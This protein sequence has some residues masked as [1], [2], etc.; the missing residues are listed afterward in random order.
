[1]P[2]KPPVTFPTEKRALAEFGKRLKLARLRR[3]LSLT[4]VA[5]RCNVS[6]TSMYKVEAGDPA[7]TLGLY[8]R[9]LKVLGLDKDF[10]ALAAED[11]VGRKLQDLAIEPAPRKRRKTPAAAPGLADA[12]KDTQP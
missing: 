7:V 1:M 12:S 9:V 6:R 2:S 11:K 8:F 4:I 5:G 3:K 10:D